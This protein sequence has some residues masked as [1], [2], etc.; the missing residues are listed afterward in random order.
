VGISFSKNSLSKNSKIYFKLKRTGRT[1][2]GIMF[3]LPAAVII[4]AF[5]ILPAFLSF[6]YSI[7]DW[8][9]ISSHYTYIGFD[10]FKKVIT[11]MEFRQLFVNSLFLIVLYVPVLNI[12]SL[13]LAVLIYDIGRIGNFYKVILFLPNILSMVVVGVIWRVIYNP[14]IGPLALVLDKI[15]L[16]FLIQDWLGQRSTVLP[17]LSVSIIWFALGFYIMIYLGGLSTIPNDIYDAA[18]IDGCKWRHKFIHIIVPMVAQSITI[19][20]VIS[21]IGILT[22]FDLPYVLTAGGPGYASQ[23]MALMVYFYAF[24]SMQ[25]GN[26]MALAIILTFITM[27]VAVF[28]LRL[29]RK[30]EDIY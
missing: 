8:N 10:N 28:Q 18:S 1:I 13:L 15:G 30:R 27:I 6:R 23:T 24:K 19:N 11:A 12:F 16:G 5:F 7:T 14:A 26:A 2:G 4:I 29:L 25:Q 22:I 9:G 3:V 20:I 21:T 17:A